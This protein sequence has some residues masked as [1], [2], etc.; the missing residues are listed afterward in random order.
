[1]YISDINKETDYTSSRE[2]KTRLE[3]RNMDLRNRNVMSKQNKVVKVS[4]PIEKTEDKI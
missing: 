2:E 1:M 3:K 4:D